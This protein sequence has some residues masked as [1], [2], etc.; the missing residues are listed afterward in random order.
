VYRS[1]NKSFLW[2]VAGSY[3]CV[4]RYDSS[5][6]KV[7]LY[8]SL[9]VNRVSCVVERRVVSGCLSTS[10]TFRFVVGN[11]V[12][13]RNVSYLVSVSN[14]QVTCAIGIRFVIV[15][16]ISSRSVWF[17][18]VKANNSEKCRTTWGIDLPTSCQVI[19]SILVLISS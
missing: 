15:A 16:L 5:S 11:A 13:P 9:R 19:Q 10:R 3:V 18:V 7:S 8:E 1:F 12:S 6:P 17:A 14:P 2:S 4:Y